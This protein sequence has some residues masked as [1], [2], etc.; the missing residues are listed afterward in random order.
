VLYIAREP[1]HGNRTWL[2]DLD[3]D[4]PKPITEEGIFGFLLSPDDRWLLLATRARQALPGLP[5]P[6]ILPMGGGEP[7]EIVGLRPDDFI[8][9]WTSDDQLYVG[10]AHPERGN[11]HIERLNPVTGVRTS[12][13]DLHRTSI[14]GVLPDLPIFTPDG[15]TYAVDYRIRLADLYVMSGVQ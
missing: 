13:R 14:T 5:Q 12:F 7:M 8:L 2:Q 1:G 15:A 3:S 10:I 11:F 6:G 9:G 4:T